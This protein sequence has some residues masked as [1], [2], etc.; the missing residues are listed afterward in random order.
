MNSNTALSNLKILD[1]TT[2]LPGPYATLML[3]DMGA[4]VLKISS[5]SKFDL[6]TD[7]ETKVEDTNLTAKALWI[8]RNKKSLALNLKTP[9]GI[10]IVKKLILHYDIII[11]Q[12]RPGVMDKLGLSYEKLSKINPKL[13]YCSITGYGQSGPYKNRAGHDINYLSKSGLMSHS[14][15]ESSGPTLYNTQIADIAGGSLHSIIGIL[16]AVNYRNL[17]GCGQYI[18]ISMLDCIIPLNSLD[19]TDFLVNSNEPKPEEKLLN[20]GTFYD[21][22]ETRD[23]RYL[24][25]GSLE[26]KFFNLFANAIEL[27]ELINEIKD[28]KISRESKEKIKNKIKEKTLSQWTNIFKDIDCCV[29]PVS[30]LTEALVEDEQIKSRGVI[31]EIP[32]NEA[33]EV[34]QYAMPIKFSKTKAQ[35]NHLGRKVGYDNFEILSSLG[36]SESEILDLEKRSVF[37]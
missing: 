8:N 3:A 6:V 29:E 36:Y 15:R 26:P 34:R 4:E 37:D 20:G 30:N 35:Y 21:F 17:T 12:F 16:A 2:L 18:D 9:E 7:G 24:S 33:D 22:Y 13:I 23:G 14:G 1:F 19:G 27:P 32:I 28:F 11:E 5:P 25:V 10:E 31:V